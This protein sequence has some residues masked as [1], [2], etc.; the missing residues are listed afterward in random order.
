MICT[1]LTDLSS[2]EATHLTSHKSLHLKYLFYK[3]DL[4]STLSI[5]TLPFSSSKGVIPEGDVPIVII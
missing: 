3:L 4:S 5:T 1:L 2:K